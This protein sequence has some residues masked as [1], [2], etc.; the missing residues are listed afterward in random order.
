M[1]KD[2]EKQLSILLILFHPDLDPAGTAASRTSF[3]ATGRPW[4]LK[5]ELFQQKRGKLEKLKTENQVNPKNTTNKQIKHVS[6]L[7]KKT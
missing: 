1:H 4:H 3:Q 5:T 2:K 7:L 6:I